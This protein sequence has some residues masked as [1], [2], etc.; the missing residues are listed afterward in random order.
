LQKGKS[1]SQRLKRCATQN[2]VFQQTLKPTSILPAS[3]GA[4]S[5]SSTIV[6]AFAG[7]KLQFICGWD[8]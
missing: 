4:Q 5:R 6:R 7:S 3:R 1:L 8:L 2:R